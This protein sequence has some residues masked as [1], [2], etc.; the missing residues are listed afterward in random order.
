MLHSENIPEVTYSPPISDLF[1][2]FKINWET[3]SP[4]LWLL[5]GVLFA[6]FVLG[7]I[8]KYQDD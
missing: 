6:F 2:F 1:N 5:Y 3:L 4:A 7:I 8:K